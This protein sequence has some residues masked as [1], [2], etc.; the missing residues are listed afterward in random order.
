M[1]C[2]P[3]SNGK[4]DEVALPDPVVVRDLADAL[5]RPAH[6][7]IAEM[8]KMNIFTT[9][10]TEIGFADASA[11]C[12]HFGVLARRKGTEEAPS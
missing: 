8:M 11:I 2:S 9:M 4:P 6:E 1:E 12:L 10:G 7:I 3:E 5:K